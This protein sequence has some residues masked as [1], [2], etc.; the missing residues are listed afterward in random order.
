MHRQKR[1]QEMWDAPHEHSNTVH[2]NKIYS[3]TLLTFGVRK[4]RCKQHL[5]IG[6]APARTVLGLQRWAVVSTL[7]RRCCNGALKLCWSTQGL[8]SAV[9]SLVLL[10]VGVQI[11]DLLLHL[12]LD[13][14]IYRER[15]FRC[16]FP[17][18]RCLK[19]SPQEIMVSSPQ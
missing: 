12:S 5:F 3:I 1:E 17:Q 2:E 18:S 7:G 19:R 6:P 4:W 9:P 8:L 11:I 15:A 13:P 14:S 10:G 16:M